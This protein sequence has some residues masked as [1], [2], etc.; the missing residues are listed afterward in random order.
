MR[1]DS[2]VSPAG[3]ATTAGVHATKLCLLRREGE[4]TNPS[5]L[6]VRVRDANES[7][8]KMAQSLGVIASSVLLV[9]GIIMMGWFGEAGI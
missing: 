1:S 8:Y 9:A 5:I 3:H 2:G 4:E 7:L 6:L